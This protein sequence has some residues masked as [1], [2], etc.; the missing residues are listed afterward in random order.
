MTTITT[1]NTTI[2]VT[3]ENTTIV[4]TQPVSQSVVVNSEVGPQ[5]AS[6]YATAVQGGFQGTEED[7]VNALM[8]NP[9]D[10]VVTKGVNELATLTVDFSNRL[11][12]SQVI[13]SVISITSDVLIT[14][15]NIQ[16]TNKTISFKV[17]GGV[18]N[19]GYK[20]DIL[21]QTSSPSSTVPATIYLLNI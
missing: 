4:V 12:T 18:L 1:D 16:F 17:N 3:T 15:S 10:V 7:W 13:T 11:Q 2:V 8:G 14:I 20:L 21:V 6:A 9:K 19:G 5:G